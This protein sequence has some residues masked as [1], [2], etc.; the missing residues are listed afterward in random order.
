MQKRDATELAAQS[1]LVQALRALSI[2]DGAGVEARQGEAVLHAV[3][4]P[5]EPVQL[6]LCLGLETGGQEDPRPGELAA[7]EGGWQHFDTLAAAYAAVLDHDQ[8]VE[9]QSLAIREAR[10]DLVDEATLSEMLMRLADYEASR[11]AAAN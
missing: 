7:V 10:G 8:A 1:V 2:T 6:V 9:A 3:G 5:V 4:E 11:D